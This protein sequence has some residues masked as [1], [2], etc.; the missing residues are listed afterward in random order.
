MKG[1]T[2]LCRKELRRT[3]CVV[4]HDELI[5]EGVTLDCV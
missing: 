4:N 5:C 3:A 1:R 2:A